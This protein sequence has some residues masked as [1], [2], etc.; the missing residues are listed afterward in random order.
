[1]R[2]APCVLVSLT[3]VLCVGAC[4]GSARV[5]AGRGAS[6]AV[7]VEQDRAILRAL[8]TNLERC[9]FG[10]DRA[11]VRI[12]DAVR[13]L[14]RA[15]AAGTSFDV[16]FADPPYEGATAQKVVDIAAAAARPLCGLLVVEH[17]NPVFAAEGGALALERA[18][19]FG[20]TK[21]SYFRYRKEGAADEGRDGAVSRDV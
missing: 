21:V 12:G 5:D 16:I 2:L 6:R 1:M 18:R 4:R 10:A 11:D 8:R 13:Y 3:A 19:Q 15:A 17:G 14:A 9:G 20:G 7:F